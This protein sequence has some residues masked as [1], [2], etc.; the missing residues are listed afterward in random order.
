[1]DAED[2]VEDGEEEE[3]DITL[4]VRAWR[5]GNLLLWCLVRLLL[6][7]RCCLVVE[8]VEVEDKSLMYPD[9]LPH[10]FQPLPLSLNPQ[11]TNEGENDHEV[12]HQ[13]ERV[14]I[15]RDRDHG[16]KAPL[17]VEAEG[18]ADLN[19]LKEETT[20]GKID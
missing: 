10:L 11:R 17:E 8:D 15:T 19:I 1:M 16:A 18:V 9:P 13:G 5:T 7:E 2:M 3:R 14:Q 12:I 6:P 4:L 20:L